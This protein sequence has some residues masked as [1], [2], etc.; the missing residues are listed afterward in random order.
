[1]TR[2]KWVVSCSVKSSL[3]L[4]ISLFIHLSI[5]LFVWV[6]KISNNPHLLER[7]QEI[8]RVLGCLKSK[9]SPRKLNWNF[10]RF[11]VGCL[12]RNLPM[13]YCIL[14]LCFSNFF[15]VLSSP[16]HSLEKKHIFCKTV[17]VNLR[18]SHSTVILGVVQGVPG[19]VQE[20][21]K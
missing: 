4:F 3:A 19:T 13:G 16:F 21:K 18:T 15:P 12:S 11:F 9:T 6:Q 1:M 2:W 10:L 20:R 7:A 8:W 5:Y 17:N 14:K